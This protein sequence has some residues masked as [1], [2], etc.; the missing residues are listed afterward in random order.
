MIGSKSLPGWVSV[1]KGKSSGFIDITGSEIGI[2]G[3][4]AGGGRNGCA[5]GN[6]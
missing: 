3:G 6:G 1:S 2:D 4:D 5:L